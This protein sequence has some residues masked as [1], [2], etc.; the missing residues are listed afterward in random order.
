MEKADA[1]IYYQSCAGMLTGIL[2]WFCRRHNRKFVF[3]LAHDS[4]CVPGKQLIHLWRDRKLY[5][6][7]LRRADLIAA[8]GV[9]QV[10]LLAEN[11]GLDS[12]PVNMAVDVPD[13]A[14]RLRKDIDVLWINNLRQFKRPELAVELARLIPDRTLTM[15]GGPTGGSESLYAAV[16]EQAE[17]VSNLNFLGAI[18]YHKVNDYIERARVFVNTSDWEGFPNSFLQAWIRGVPVV[19]FFDPDGLIV[20]QQLGA[21]PV[22]LP[23]MA[24]KVQDLLSNDAVREVIADR[25]RTFV[26]KNYS[27]EVIV[28]IYEDLFASLLNE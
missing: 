1:D 21:V 18:P 9:R 26:L 27:P 12:V 19:S 7:G 14:E 22:N 10:A 13:D 16:K 11:Y 3:R 17:S 8:Q 5:E 2:A 24:A 20:G 23:D 4:D 28:K 25:A 15:I 6:Y